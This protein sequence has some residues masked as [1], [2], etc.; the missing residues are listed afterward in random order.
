VGGWKLKAITGLMLTQKL[1]QKNSKIGDFL[2]F[3]FKVKN[4][5]IFCKKLI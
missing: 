5:A 3:I 2:I 4:I 1:K